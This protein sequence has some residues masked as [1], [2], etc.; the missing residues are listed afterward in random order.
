MNPAWLLLLL[1]LTFLAGFASAC[2]V[3]AQFDLD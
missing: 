1:P 3:L 2:F